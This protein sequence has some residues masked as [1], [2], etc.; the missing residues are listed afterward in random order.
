MLIVF[1]MSLSPVG[2]LRSELLRSKKRIVNIRLRERNSA[3]LSHHAEPG[4]PL[5]V[6]SK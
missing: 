4:D 2:V 3:L 1:V 5:Q 6:E